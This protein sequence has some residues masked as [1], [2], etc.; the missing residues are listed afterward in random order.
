MP[1]FLAKSPRQAI[2]KLDL[3]DNLQLTSCYYRSGIR[4]KTANNYFKM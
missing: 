3:L 4:H 1:G 2:S